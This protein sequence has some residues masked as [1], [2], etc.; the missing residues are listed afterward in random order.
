MGG[1]TPKALRLLA[2]RPILEHALLAVA[3]HPWVVQAVIAVPS[4]EVSSVSAALPDTRA[5]AV[6]VVPGGASRRSSVAAALAEVDDTCDIVLV[7]DAARPL[8]PLDLVD[9]VIRA[10]SGGAAA[11]IPGLPV[12]DTIKRIDAAGRVVET[13][14]RDMLRAVQTPQGFRREVLV[15]AHAAG[16]D[17]DWATDDAA[18]VE[19]AGHAVVV[20][21][22]DP[23]AMKIT[24]PADLLRAEAILAT[25]AAT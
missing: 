1:G 14:P 13:P 23:V 11:A 18:M 9:R 10:V 2:G 21:D 3:A 24:T 16:S 22:G 6:R 8:V 15:A 7:H 20:V 17:A 19:H 5:V 4:D 12:V 25:A